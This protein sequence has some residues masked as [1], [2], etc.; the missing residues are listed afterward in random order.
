MFR[1]TREFALALESAGELRRVTAPVSPILE[2]AAIADR[3]S[4]TRCYELPSPPTRAKDPRFHDRGGVAL[5]FEK[6]RGSKIP[7]LINAFG[8]YRRMEVA[9]GCH[10]DANLYEDGHIAGGYEGLAAK[11][12]EFTKPAPP[13]SLGEALS[14]L[15]RFAPLLKIAPRTVRKARCQEIVYAGDSADLSILPII[16]CWPLDG[17]FAA[18][19]YPADVNDN[20]PGVDTS[21]EFQKQWGGRYITL[22]HIH[23]IHPD[24]IDNPKPASHNIGMYRVQ[25]LSKNRLAMHWHM[26]HDGAAHWRAWK[27]LGKRMPVA[28]A[29]G[30]ESVLPFAATAPLPP[31][32]SELLFAGFLNRE[33]IPMVRAK[34][35]PIRVPANSEIVIEGFVSTDAGFVNY[36]PRTDGPLGP[37]AVF[38]GPFGD[39]T[40]YY[41]MPDRYPIMEVTA[42]THRRNPIYPT[43]IVGLPPQEDYY[44][45]KA[46]ERIFLPLLKTIVPDIEDYHLP[47]FGAF[48]NAACVQID[49]TYPLHAR[50]VM[51]A[52]W[53]AG[54][55]SWTKNI[56]VV[57]ADADVHDALEVMRLAGQRCHPAR[58]IEITR[59]PLDILDHAAPFLGAG[60]KLGFD[61]TRKIRGE[62][63]A[64]IPLD[65]LSAPPPAL[66][67]ADAS[68][69]L[70]SVREI[71]NVADASLPAE[72]ARTWLFVSITKEHDA[73]ADTIADAL[74]RIVT[75]A[76]PRYIVM[77]DDTVNI[78][79]IDE[80]LFHWCANTDAARDMR[81]HHDRACFDATTKSPRPAIESSSGTATNAYDWPVRAW[82]PV[83]EMSKDILDLVDQRWFEY[84]IEEG[85]HTIQ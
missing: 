79:N 73:D 40:G 62:Q 81:I 70:E 76:P 49:K 19:G 77:L 80:A 68:V 53:G 35:V 83:I 2:I 29:L 28:I 60:T 65:D 43:T 30:G 22:A 69:Y 63:S 13:R 27:K 8:S 1:T 36:D 84:R 26:H 21:A 15:K 37:G 7:V 33:G 59:G 42:I 16:K 9:L 72:L 24:D 17:D 74:F 3:V 46:T 44:L 48:H 75:D 66:S 58:D 45:G 10:G 6:V 20:I 71:A 61:C 18:L 82:P 50:R 5:L 11:I 25:V 31:G 57:D 14:M 47:L 32:I 12:A 78:D 64:D 54:Q 34:T 67:D 38:E 85:N 23:T 4:K 51:H 52:C 56:F 41:S 55:M 39:H